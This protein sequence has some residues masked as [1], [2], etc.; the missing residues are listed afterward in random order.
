MILSPHILR[1]WELELTYE[2][3]GDTVQPITLANQDFNETQTLEFLGFGPHCMSLRQEWRQCTHMV[4]PN[5]EVFRI[6]YKAVVANQ[7][8]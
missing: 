8:T 3:W 1:Y 5:S 6:N 2:F 4:W 7:S